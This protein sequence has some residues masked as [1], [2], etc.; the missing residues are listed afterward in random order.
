VPREEAR[1]LRPLRLQLVTAAE[2]ETVQRLASRMTGVDR[3]LERF[4]ILNGLERGA[5][6]QPGE[7]YKVVVE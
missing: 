4:L 7:R 1:A 2:G 5:R 3:P 6:L